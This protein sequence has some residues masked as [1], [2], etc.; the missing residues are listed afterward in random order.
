MFRL[1]ASLIDDF[2]I[3]RVKE[4]IL[5]RLKEKKISQQISSPEEMQRFTNKVIEETGMKQVSFS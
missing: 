2:S 3:L 5:E 4:F 1:F